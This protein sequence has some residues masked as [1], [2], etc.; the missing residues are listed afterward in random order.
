MSSID[1]TELTYQLRKSLLTL[2]RALVQA[3]RTNDVKAQCDIKKCI[4]VIKKTINSSPKDK[5]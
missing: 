3:R 2:S 1:R 5:Q 4:D